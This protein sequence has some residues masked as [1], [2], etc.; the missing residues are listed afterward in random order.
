MPCLMRSV[1]PLNARTT[2]LASDASP[3]IALPLWCAWIASRRS[4]NSLT[5]LLR[6]AAT[7]E[8]RCEASACGRAR[9]PRLAT[10]LV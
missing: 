9:S 6:S 1:S 10:V 3:V 5:G 4:E 8:L 2:A 7:L